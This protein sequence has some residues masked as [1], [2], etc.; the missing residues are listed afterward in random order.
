MGNRRRLPLT[1]LSSCYQCWFPEAM[2]RRY[3]CCGMVVGI[4]QKFRIPAELSIAVLNA[5]QSRMN[6][7]KKRKN[8]HLNGSPSFSELFLHS[9]LCKQPT[10]PVG[11]SQRS[12]HPESWGGLGKCGK[13]CNCVSDRRLH[14]SNWKTSGLRK[15]VEKLV[16]LVNPPRRK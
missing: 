12:I 7:E 2:T 8:Q 3:Y 6:G 9:F 5:P 1:H 15:R 10:R 16:F 14:Y 13:V 4:S 11:I